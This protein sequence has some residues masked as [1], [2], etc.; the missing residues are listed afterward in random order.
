MLVSGDQTSS[1]VV[2]SKHSPEEATPA[3]DAVT[4]ALLLVRAV[5]EPA[6]VQGMRTQTCLPLGRVCRPSSLRQ[7]AIKLTENGY[8]KY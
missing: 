4:S 7:R 2:A 8:G 5:T 1:V 6:Q 3:A